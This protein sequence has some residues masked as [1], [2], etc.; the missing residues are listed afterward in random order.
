MSDLETTINFL[1]EDKI[2]TV[3]SSQRKWV[4]K[5]SKYAEDK[6][7]GVTVTHINKDGSKMFEVPVS[8]LK[9]SPPRKVNMSE[10][11]KQVLVQ[12]LRENRENK[13]KNK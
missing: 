9:I 13:S 4:N 3:F 5:L 1:Q 10:E 11:Q 7:S 2:M 8:W 6:E 12:R